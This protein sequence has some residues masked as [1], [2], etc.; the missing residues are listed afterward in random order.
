MAASRYIIYLPI[1]TLSLT[2]LYAIH[3]AIF[4]TSYYASVNVIGTFKDTTS[5]F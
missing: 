5:L 4:I 3:T 2:K 1:Y